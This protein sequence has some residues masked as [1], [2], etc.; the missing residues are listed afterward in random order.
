MRNSNPAS[1]EYDSFNPSHQALYRPLTVVGWKPYRMTIVQRCGRLARLAL[2]WVILSVF[3]TL[4]GI[5]GQSVKSASQWLGTRE[6]GAEL[7][8]ARSQNLQVS[9]GRA[10]TGTATRQL[11]L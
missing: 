8:S 1:R 7:A 4:P 2:E 3:R 9:A 6:Q 5:V 10:G 11:R